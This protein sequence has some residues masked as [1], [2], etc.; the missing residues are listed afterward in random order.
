MNSR[1]AHFCDC[2]R[3]LNGRPQF[4]SV[5]EW[6][7]VVNTWRRLRTV[8]LMPFRFPLIAELGAR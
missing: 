7:A 4:Y 2:D 8:R 6:Q 1:H 3:C 5:T